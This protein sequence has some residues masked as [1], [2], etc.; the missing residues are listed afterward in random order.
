MSRHPVYSWP[1]NRALAL[2]AL[3]EKQ[4]AIVSIATQTAPTDNASHEAHRAQIRKQLR[5][6]L[7]DVLSTFLECAPVDIDLAHTPGHAPK[8]NVC[9]SLPDKQFGISISHEQGLSIAAIYLDGFIGVDLIV[10]DPRIEWHAV[11]QLYLGAQVSAEIVKQP[12]SQQATY[13]SL[14]W[15]NF[16]A[17]LKCHQHALTEWSPE[18]EQSLNNCVLHELDLPQGYSG[19]LA[20][21]SA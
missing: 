7:T 20:L 8:R 5:A 4:L 16:E 18:L 1:E 14:Q 3:K 12:A 19:A 9:S 11:A 13:F 6:A 17:K 10:I 15:A 2:H 21:R